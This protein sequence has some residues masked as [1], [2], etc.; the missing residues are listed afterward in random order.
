MKLWIVRIERSAYVM[1][2]TEDEAIEQQEHIENWEWAEVSVEA[3][4]GRT[5]SEWDDKCLVYHAGCEDVTLRVARDLCRE[6]S[7]PEQTE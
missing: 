7:T 5:M 1:A 3:A 4:G 2:E 6:V